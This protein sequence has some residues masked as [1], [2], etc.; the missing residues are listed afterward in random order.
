MLKHSHPNIAAAAII[1]LLIAAA[2][3]VVLSY[4][5]SKLPRAFGGPPAAARPAAGDQIGGQAMSTPPDPSK[6]RK[7]S[8]EEEE[9][10][11]H[12]GTERPFTG[13]YDEHFAPGVY[14]CRRCGAMLYRSEDKFPSHCGWPAFDDEIP[15]AVKRVPDA[16]GARTEII[17]ANCG[18]HLGHVFT[19]EHLTPKDTRHCVNA[20][21]LLFVPQEQMKV[22][23]AIFAGGC[24]WGVQ[25]W[26]QK[27]PGILRTT[28]GYI[29]GTKENPT[30]EDV[31]THTTG[32]FEGVEVLWDPVRASFEQVAKAFFEIHDFTQTDGQG[33]DIGPQY[34]SAIFTTDDDQRR[35]VEKLISELTARGF[36]VATQVKPAPHFWPAE[37][38]HQDY[39]NKLGSQ[40]YCHAR[41]KLW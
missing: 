25:Y 24:F 4:Q 14:T 17:C 32:H 2:V 38:Y 11:V 23:R 8:P 18:A 21:S 27:L 34:K 37:A 13:E 33:P 41:R 40:P 22:G 39:Y 26:L 1:V 7:L 3:V 15:G 35:V 30:Y 19:G 28:A 16:D 29:G 12:R 6:Y 36:K 10:I 20:I 31:C 5:A 9:V